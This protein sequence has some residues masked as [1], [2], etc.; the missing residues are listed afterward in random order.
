M[1][2]LPATLREPGLHAKG[3]QQP[4]LPNVL[5]AVFSTPS[6]GLFSHPASAVARHWDKTGHSTP[7]QSNRRISFV[8]IRG[9]SSFSWQKQHTKSSEFVHVD[10]LL[11]RLFLFL[12][13]NRLRPRVEGS[14]LTGFLI[15]SIPDG[16]PQHSSY[17]GKWSINLSKEV[18]P[19]A[20]REGWGHQVPPPPIL[21]CSSCYFRVRFEN[22]QK[23][24][25]G[26]LHPSSLFDLF[27]KKQSSSH[28]DAYV[29]S[30]IMLSNVLNSSVVLHQF[31]SKWVSHR[32]KPS[33]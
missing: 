22:M 16:V 14:I 30:L 10:F 28:T 25:K 21:F 23:Q 20:G 11:P 5:V 3:F 2:A 29:S 19:A 6:E 12:M 26:K 27:L 8:R 18:L 13:A 7:S 33:L 15:W 4:K 24:N 17:Q 31:P 1:G 9:N 32:Q